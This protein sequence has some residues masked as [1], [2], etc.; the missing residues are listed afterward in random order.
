MLNGHGAR[1]VGVAEPNEILVSQTVRDALVGSDVVLAS[2][3][4]HELKGVPGHWDL[5]AVEP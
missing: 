2:R 5:F 4:S 1:V 3:G